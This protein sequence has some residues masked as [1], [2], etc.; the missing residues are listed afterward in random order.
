MLT[1]Y[2]N[3]KFNIKL[4][5]HK[6]RKTSTSPFC[7]VR[8]FVLCLTQWLT[9]FIWITFEGKWYEFRSRWNDSFVGLWLDGSWFPHPSP[10]S[11]WTLDLSFQTISVPDI[12]N[13][14]FPIFYP[15][16]V[17]PSISFVQLQAQSHG[18]FLVRILFCYSIIPYNFKSKAVSF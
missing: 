5:V 12:S 7:E 17:L 18:S 6:S 14:P 4:I 1:F 2:K 3:S 8:P 10:L 9:Q 15:L 11:H 16:W 13:K